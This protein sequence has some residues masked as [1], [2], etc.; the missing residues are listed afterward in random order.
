[1]A[2]NIRSETKIR[3]RIESGRYVETGRANSLDIHLH[4]TDVDIVIPFGEGA[5]D[6]DGLAIS[7]R[8]VCAAHRIVADRVRLR[9]TLVL[10]DRANR[11]RADGRGARLDK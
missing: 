4:V 8:I 7:F 11:G 9:R 6:P 2:Q 10:D 3:A 5:R 1:V